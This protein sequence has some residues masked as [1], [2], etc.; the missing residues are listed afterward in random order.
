MRRLIRPMRI[1]AALLC[2]V[3]SWDASTC[4]AFWLILRW[5]SGWNFADGIPVRD[6]RRATTKWAFYLKALHTL[7]SVHRCHDETA[8]IYFACALFL[9]AIRRNQRVPAARLLWLGN[10]SIIE[11]WLRA[12]ISPVTDRLYGR[13]CSLLFSRLFVAP[14][15]KGRL[16]QRNKSTWKAIRANKE[17]SQCDTKFRAFVYPLLPFY[18]SSF[19]TFTS[20][21]T[22]QLQVEERRSSSCGP[23]R[24]DNDRRTAKL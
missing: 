24:P 1:I 2:V 16:V 22:F 10:A 17:I 14:G 20:N 3:W 7:R 15:N 6:D 5:A 4:S 13:R 21:D 23:I 8:R 12:F 19:V 9:V 11:L 18:P